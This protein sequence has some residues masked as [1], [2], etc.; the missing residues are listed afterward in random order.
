MIRTRRWKTED[1]PDKYWN[2]C[3]CNSTAI[4]ESN[5]QCRWTPALQLILTI[6][7]SRRPTHTP[8]RPRRCAAFETNHHDRRRPL[9]RPP[10]RP[11]RRIRPRRHRGHP[12]PHRPRDAVSHG[13]ADGRSHPGALVG[14][15]A[16]A[17]A[18]ADAG[19]GAWTARA[20]DRV[21]P[22]RRLS[23]TSCFPC[24]PPSTSLR[25]ARPR[26]PPRRRRPSAPRPGAPRPWGRRR[27]FRR[28]LGP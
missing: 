9:R 12:R 6:S 28:R 8:S 13:R 22:R 20:A 15:L 27:P 7:S 3:K 21:T 18:G 25:A 5:E 16:G 23:L 14:A 2:M 10:R 11:A 4:H 24:P 26:R 1:A 19:A 17:L